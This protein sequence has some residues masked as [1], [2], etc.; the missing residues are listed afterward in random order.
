MGV[1]WIKGFMRCLQGSD[2]LEKYLKMK[3]CLENSLKTKTSISKGC[4]K[5]VHRP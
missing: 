2:S 4:L 1:S 3:E 5:S